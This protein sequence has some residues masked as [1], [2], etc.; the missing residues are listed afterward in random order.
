[1]DLPELSTASMELKFELINPSMA[2]NSGTTYDFPLGRFTVAC[3]KFPPN[4]TCW[5]GGTRFREFV[6]LILESAIVPAPGNS[7]LRHIVKTS[8]G[9]PRGVVAVLAGFPRPFH[10][11][12]LDPFRPPS[13]KTL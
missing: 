3:V 9:V 2:S 6:L 8:C 10:P 11:C 1:M 5:S 12:R 4:A 13:R 7:V